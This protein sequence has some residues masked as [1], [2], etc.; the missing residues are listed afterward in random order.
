MRLR[1]GQVAGLR[2]CL[3]GALLAVG[4]CAGSPSADAPPPAEARMLVMPRLHHDAM[5][6]SAEEYCAQ[7][8]GEPALVDWRYRSTFGKRGAWQM[9]TMWECRDAGE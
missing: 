6:A 3:L 4:A 5:R 8:G 2:G 9:Q 7:F 1:I